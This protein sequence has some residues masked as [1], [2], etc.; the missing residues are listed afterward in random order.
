MDERKL[1]S[2]AK[3]YVLIYL[4]TKDRSFIYERFF[5][6]PN[7]EDMNTGSS[8]HADKPIMKRPAQ[9]LCWENMG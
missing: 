2:P 4:P 6:K 3:N 8:T 7:A 5:F 9:H 1:T